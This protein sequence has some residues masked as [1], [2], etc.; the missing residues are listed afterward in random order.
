MRVLLIKLTSMGDL[1]HALPALSD[2]QA[3]IPSIQFDWV[4]DENF[5]E[6][7]SWHPAVNIII[8]SA[9][10]RWRRHY[11]KHW[12]EIRGF[13]KQLRKTHY[14]LIIDGQ[15]NLKSALV[16]LF[17]KGL[18][19]GFDKNSVR[20][21][22]AHWVYK[23]QL[24]HSKQDHAITRIRSLF[25][26]A[27]AYP[28]PTT[29]PD[30]GLDRA[31]FKAPKLPLPK[32]YL[33]FIHNASWNTKLWPED[34]WQQLMVFCLATN[35]TILLPAGNSEELARSNRLAHNHPQIIAL[36]RLPL[37]EIAFLLSHA[38]ATV[39]VDTGL[40]HLSAALNIPTITLY[41]ATDAELIGATG[42][43]QVHLQSRFAC[44][45]CYLHKCNYTQISPV[46]PACFTELTPQLVWQTLQTLLPL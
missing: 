15:S 46:Q 26:Q 34:Y 8:K 1:I 20:E 38:I 7:A 12:P 18:K 22:P 17:S 10:R 33:M 21:Y 9:H 14:D 28:L 42:L 16:T 43:H 19:C 5:A 13:V 35:L 36:P 29:P 44:A 31:L 23:K 2:A 3:A 45:P 41:G 4:I 27:L 6:I 25:S 40:S 37:S 24:A 39:S 11:K 30:F 32:R